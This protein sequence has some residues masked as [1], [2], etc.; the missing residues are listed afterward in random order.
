MPGAAAA[1]AVAG[2]GLA[3]GGIAPPAWGWAG[4]GLAAV[5]VAALAFRIR[6]RLSRLELAFLGALGL[7]AA[8]A[9]LSAAWSRSLPSSVLES[10]RLLV[11]AAAAAA[12]LLAGRRTAAGPLLVGTLAGILVVAAANLLLRDGDAV[13]AAGQARPLADE[14]ALAILLVLGVAIALGLALA[15]T[16]P[17]ARIGAA[18]AA[19]FLLVP[20]VPLGS[21]GA[22]LALVAGLVAA[23]A[24]RFGRSPLAYPAAVALGLVAAI[25][26]G[27][28]FDSQRE[29]LWRVASDEARSEPLAGTGAGTYPRVWL[30]QRSDAVQEDDAHNVYLETLAEVG[31]LGLALLAAALAV[32]VAA[33][34]SVRHEPL[35]PAAAS[36]YAAF[37]VHAGIDRDWAVPAVVVAALAAAACAAPAGAAART[38]GDRRPAPAARARPRGDGRG[39]CRARRPRREHGRRPRGGRCCPGLLGR[40]RDPCPARRLARAVV[41]RGA[42]APRRGASTRAATST[43]PAGACA[44]PSPGT[45]AIPSSGSRSRTASAATRAPAPSRRRSGSTRSGSHRGSPGPPSEEAPST[46]S[47]Q[48]PIPTCTRR[49]DETPASR[50]SPAFRARTKNWTL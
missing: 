20:L 16:R 11:Y 3:D 41:G 1:V 14:H 23:G 39:A 31:P 34:A 8:W 7:V 46:P 43:P 9:A 29:E 30:Q 4:L 13:T 33:A 32:P 6:V 12:F 25:V 26:V 21:R 38:G 19:G 18:A 17:P 36:A 35:A 10:Q 24:L 22:W 27:V 40:R 28:R 37:L 49:R 45:R 15:T 47:A 42:A 44:G 5:A 50:S 48:R 2:L